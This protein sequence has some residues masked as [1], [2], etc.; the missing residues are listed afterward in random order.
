MTPSPTDNAQTVLVAGGGPIGLAVAIDLALR[1]VRTIVFEARLPDESFGPRTNQTNARSMEHFRRWGIADALRRNDPIDPEMKRDVRFMTRVVGGHTLANLEGGVEWAARFPFAAET[2]EWAPNPAIEKTLRDRAAELYEI[3]LRFGIEVTGFAQTDDGVT[4]EFVDRDGIAGSASGAYLVGADGSR[5]FV[6]RQLGVKLEGLPN[7]T[8]AMAWH[9]R[10]P[11]LKELARPTGLSAFYWLINE[12]RTG[13]IVFAQDSD[14]TYLFF[15]APAPD[16]VDPDD[17]SSV[18]AYYLRQLGTDTELESLGGGQLMVHSVMAPRYDHGRVL[19][20]GDAAH[21]ISPY[22]GF[23]M[24]IGIGDAADL[25]WKIGATLQGWGGSALIPSYS[26]E[27]REAEEW[28]LDVCAKN[29]SLIGPNMARDHMEQDGPGGDA[30]R[31][32]VTEMIFEKKV[33]ELKSMGAQLGYQYNGSPI[34]AHQPNPPESTAGDYIPTASPGSRLPHV[35][36]DDTTSLYDRLGPWF[37]LVVTE[38]GPDTT[39]F[40]AAAHDR[41]VPLLVLTPGSQEL[42]ELCEAKLVLVRPDQHVAWRGDVAPADVETLIDLVRG[43][44]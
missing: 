14:D 19:L 15:D 41:G 33:S 28:I 4:V 32:E 24:N 26:Q 43:H 42:A 29:T 39:P 2:P 21:L 37:T 35:W 36:L 12:D 8:S 5:S 9:V 13:L 44:V 30:A 1:G 6:R 34:I 23:G 16:G 38:E 7:L 31:A 20:A 10:A 40:E 22:G 11:K 17:W 18:S 27:R 3:D 25:G